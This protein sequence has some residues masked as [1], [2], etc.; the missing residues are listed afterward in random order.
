MG[1]SVFALRAMQK[2][3]TS[4]MPQKRLPSKLLLGLPA[5]CLC[6]KQAER[7]THTQKVDIMAHEQTH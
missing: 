7:A 2:V 4:G 3:Q 1:C 5:E 6:N